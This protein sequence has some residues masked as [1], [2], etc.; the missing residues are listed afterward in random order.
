MAIDGDDLLI[1]R[2]F[3]LDLRHYSLNHFRLVRSFRVY[4][5]NIHVCVTSIGLNS[6][7]IVA[8]AVSLNEK[9]FIDFIQ[10]HSQEFLRRIALDTNEHIFYPINMHIHGQWFAKSSIPYVNI[11]HCLLSPDGQMIRLKL[12]SDQDNFI[13]SLKVNENRKWL[14]IGRQNAL[15][16]YSFIC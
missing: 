5:E 3:G 16:L 6:R 10:L 4:K 8:L 1:N 12:F 7:K 15:E 9:Q 14:A 13:R 11:G 2:S